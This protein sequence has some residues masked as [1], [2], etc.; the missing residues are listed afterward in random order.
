M[1]ASRSRKMRVQVQRWPVRE[2]VV[3][4]STVVRHRPRRRRIGE[5][6]E[7]CTRARARALR[8]RLARAMRRARRAISEVARVALKHPEPVAAGVVAVVD[9]AHVDRHVGALIE[10]A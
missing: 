10:R 7:Q 2:R 4:C 6:R 5:H 8:R 3:Y 9:E 1:L